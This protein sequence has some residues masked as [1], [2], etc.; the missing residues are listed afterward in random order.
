MGI[1]FLAI[2]P[3]HNTQDIKEENLPADTIDGETKSGIYEGGV[4]HQVTGSVEALIGV[5]H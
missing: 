3:C 5:R 4:L 2:L 1:C